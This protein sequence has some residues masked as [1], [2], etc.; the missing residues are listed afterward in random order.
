MVFAIHWH[1]SA[2]DLHVFPI[3]IPFPPPHPIPTHRVFPM[4]QP[5]ALVSCIQPGLVICFILD[6][7]LKICIKCV[8]WLIFGLLTSVY[9]SFLCLDKMTFVHPSFMCLNFISS[10]NLGSY[11]PLILY[12]CFHYV[13]C[14]FIHCIHLLNEAYLCVYILVLE[15]LWNLSLWN[16]TLE[17]MKTRTGNLTLIFLIWQVIQTS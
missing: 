9:I 14:K 8:L 5:W 12:L 1:E 7:T 11:V 16:W 2:M 4:H 10:F 3:L 17:F 13:L 15:S 6:N